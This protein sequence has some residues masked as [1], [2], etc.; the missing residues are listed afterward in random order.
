MS[1]E[2]IEEISTGVDLKN[3]RIYFGLIDQEVGSTIDWNTVELCIRA[4]NKMST[5]FPKKP[6]ELHM[7][8]GGGDVYEALRLYDAIQNC[9][10]QVKFFGS[11]QIM[12]AAILVMVGCDER[13]VTA[14]A[15]IMLHHGSEETV[16]ATFT[17]RKID[18]DE[19]QRL[20]NKMLE[21]L[22]DNSRFSA[23][24]WDDLLDRDLYLTA[25]EA[26][27]LGLID[28]IV[29]AK[30]RGALRKARIKA[31]NNIPPQDDTNKLVKSLFKRI[32][33]E[34]RVSR[35]EVHLPKE[36]F[37]PSVTVDESP[38]PSEEPVEKVT[39]VDP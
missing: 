31:L 36:E 22:A 2:K 8:S 33:K 9:S 16:E 18:T 19:W 38:V 7:S 27:T 21:I 35:I 6:I 1:N 10:C 13:S 34:K 32:K 14:N 30:K 17:D 12:S 11:G 26:L 5:D 28:K 39:S 37:D 4:L 20:V 25:S 29:D 3:R 23:E 24:F 15:T